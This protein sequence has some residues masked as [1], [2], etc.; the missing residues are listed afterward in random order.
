VDEREA[1]AYDG[2]D[3]QQ[4]GR[5]RAHQVSR[6]PSA[7]AALDTSQQVVVGHLVPERLRG[8]WTMEIGPSRQL[9]PRVLERVGTVDVFVHDSDHTTAN[10]TREYRIAWRAMPTGGALL[11]DDIDANHAFVRFARRVRHAPVVVSQQRR[12]GY[13]GMLRKA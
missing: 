10:M 13:L 7:A 5:P 2:K 12:S 1:D 6:L 8:R 4:H 11:S 9:L 3:E